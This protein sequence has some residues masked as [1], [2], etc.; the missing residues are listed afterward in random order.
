MLELERSGLRR[1]IVAFAVPESNWAT[2]VSFPIF[3]ANAL[4]RLAQV[5]AGAQ[6]RA[7]TT[8]D[9]ITLR[10]APGADEIT[11]TRE[12]ATE[13]AVPVRAGN[14][15]TV[16]IGALDRAGLYT[17][18]GADPAQAL[19]A[20]NLFN[21]TE[22]AIATADTVRVAGEDIQRGGVGQAAPREIWSL[23]VLIA[24]ALLTI[25]WI[26]FALRSKV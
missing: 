21:P 17:A 14:S 13:R 25:E 12:A 1:A 4:E 20:V 24:F 5:G 6:A 2:S 7:F 10:A 18:A 22:S 3:I 19:L 11:L 8:T 16:A 9:P 15:A 23:F 26:L